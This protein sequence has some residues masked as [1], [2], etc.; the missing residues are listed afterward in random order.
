VLIDGNHVG[1]VT[2]G[3]FSPSLGH[4]ISL[5]FIPPGHPVGSAVEIDVR[6][7]LLVATVVD[8]PFVG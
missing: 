3:N 2:S 5:A 6:G 8:L 7:N 4:G 1:D